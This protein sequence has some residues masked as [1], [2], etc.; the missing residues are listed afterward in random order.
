[1][2]WELLIRLAGVGLLLI[3]FAN[4]LVPAM[5]DYR[6][7][8][9]KVDRVFGQIFRVH[10]AYTIVM[11]LGMAALCLWRPAFFL[12]ESTGRA[13]AGF[14]GLFWGS[15]FVVQLVYYDRNLR[16]RYPL[17]DVIFSAGFFSLG[18]VFLTIAFLP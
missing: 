4:F 9:A 17:W 14:M 7:N 15:R 3:A 6:A 8:L 10:A 16:R 12:E 2:K 18:A 5:L 13:V 11:V 1:M